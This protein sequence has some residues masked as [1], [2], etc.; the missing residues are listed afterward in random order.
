MIFYR[1]E[2]Y[3]RPNQDD[4]SNNFKQRDRKH[5]QRMNIG[6]LISK[7]VMQSLIIHDPKAPHK[8]FWFIILQSSKKVKPRRKKSR[9]FD[10]LQHTLL[11]NT[12]RKRG[13]FHLAF[14]YFFF[15]RV[16]ISV[17]YTLGVNF[18]RQAHAKL[19]I[20]KVKTTIKRNFGISSHSFGGMQ[21]ENTL[22]ITIATGRCIA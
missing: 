4:V 12:T 2:F 11:S 17:A 14:C 20:A 19:M 18:S 8:I 15:S 3:I 7:L 5:R 22:R 6:Q 9:T 16:P 1:K 10:T 13:G 21:T